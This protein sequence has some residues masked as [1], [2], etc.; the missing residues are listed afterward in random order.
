MS[1]RE[2]TL[3]NILRGTSDTNISF[4]DLRKLLLFF[5][6]QER[7]RGSHH[8]F[9]KEDVTEIINLQ[10]KKAKAK[11]Y[12]VKQVRNLILKYKLAGKEND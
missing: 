6:F 2:K 11:A 7:I 4:D 1:K 9:S 12:Q 3:S 5:G 10:S 8:I